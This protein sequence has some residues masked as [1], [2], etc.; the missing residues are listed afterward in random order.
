[1]T[2]VVYATACRKIVNVRW[3]L[4]LAR[5]PSLIH[6]RRRYEQTSTPNFKHTHTQTTASV[7]QAMSVSTNSCGMLRCWSPHQL[8]KSVWRRIVYPPPPT[9]HSPRN[10]TKHKRVQ[11]SSDFIRLV[12]RQFILCFKMI[13]NAKLNICS[14]ALF[15]TMTRWHGI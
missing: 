13:L 7:A 9:S 3:W 1:M 12:A 4:W 5:M 8:T 2:S 15:E 11:W 14:K 10:K 6:S